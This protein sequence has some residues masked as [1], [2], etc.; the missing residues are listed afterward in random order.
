MKVEPGPAHLWTRGVDE[1]RTGPRPPF[2]ILGCLSRIIQVSFLTIHAG[3]LVFRMEVAKAAR[4]VALPASS[5]GRGNERGLQLA[6]LWALLLFDM[7]GPLSHV[8][9]ACRGG[10]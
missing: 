8:P 1:M 3:H 10:Q 7:S 5:W 9:L 6:H 4:V 2:F